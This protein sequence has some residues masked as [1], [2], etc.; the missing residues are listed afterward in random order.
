MENLNYILRKLWQNVRHDGTSSMVNVLVLTLTFFTMLVVGVGIVNINRVTRSI[1]DQYQI[2]VYLEDGV[3]EQ[4]V[5]QVAEGLGQVQGVRQVSTLGPEQFRERFLASSGSSLEGIEGASVEIFPSVIQ[6]QLEPDFRRK[7]NLA[8]VA[9][10]IQRID[11][12]QTVETHEGWLGQLKGLAGVLGL[13]AL[14]FGIS[15]MVAAVLI[16]ANTVKLAFIKR[17]P[18]VEVMR[19]FGATRSFIEAPVILEG[20]L[21]GFIGAVLAL[22]MAWGLT[23][24]VDTRIGTIMGSGAWHIAFVPLSWIALFLALCGAVGIVGA[25]LASARTLRV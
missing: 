16:V 14:I 19:L 23:S 21:Q 17:Q 13:I 12:V 4:R 5:V 18:L 24:L 3:S 6:L 1:E 11:A 15:V 8:T 25:H 7:M 2:T 22:G 20:F 9:S 10:R